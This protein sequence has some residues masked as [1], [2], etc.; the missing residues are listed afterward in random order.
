MHLKSSCATS[1]F[2]KM[3]HLATVPERLLPC[4]PE[5]VIQRKC[6]KASVFGVCIGLWLSEIKQQY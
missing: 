2:S 5:G 6:L 4:K 1:L 3:T